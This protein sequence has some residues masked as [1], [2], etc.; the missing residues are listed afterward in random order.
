MNKIEIE[1]FNTEL[2]ELSAFLIKKDKLEIDIVDWVSDCVSFFSRINVNTT[3][4]SDFINYY[5]PKTVKEGTLDEERTLGNFVQKPRYLNGDGFYQAKSNSYL[6]KI[7][8]KVAKSIL[9]KIE[10]EERIVPFWLIKKLSEKEE[11]SNILSSLELIENNY[12]DR[13]GDGVVKNCLSLL[14]NILNKSNDLKDNGDLIKKLN[15]LMNTP[16]ILNKF[17][18]SR[19]FVIALNNSRITRN[20]QSVH[21]ENKVK[22][23]IPFLVAISTAYLVILFLEITISTGELIS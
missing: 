22:Y 12:E 15:K 5:Y 14:E 20:I 1:Q 17:G 19:E 23:D 3:I 18:V 9:K 8:F 11:Y 2:D 6:S 21:K 10:E 7:A 13:D 4:I 16:D